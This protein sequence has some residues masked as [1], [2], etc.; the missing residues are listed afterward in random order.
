VE[1]SGG[2]TRWWMALEVQS[3]MRREMT[4][5]WNLQVIMDQRQMNT[6][7]LTITMLKFNCMNASASICRK[8]NYL[9]VFLA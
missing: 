7:H 1:G 4:S 6:N 9:S 8:R 2:R 5:S 3:D